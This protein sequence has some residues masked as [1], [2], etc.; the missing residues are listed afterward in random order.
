MTS[1]V[2]LHLVSL[3]LNKF[4]P[5]YLIGRKHNTV[6]KSPGQICAIY[7]VSPPYPSCPGRLKAL[8]SGTSCYSS[9]SVKVGL[10]FDKFLGITT[11]ERSSTGL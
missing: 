3:P 1:V 10:I 6:T 2:L 4:L 11:L 5:N 8:I 7:S 9:S